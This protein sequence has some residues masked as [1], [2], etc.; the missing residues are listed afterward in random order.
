[1]APE[2]T[3]EW[4]KLLLVDEALDNPDKTDSSSSDSDDGWQ[5]SKSGKRRIQQRLR[6]TRSLPKRVADFRSKHMTGKLI[7]RFYGDTGLPLLALSTTIRIRAWQERYTSCLVDN[8]ESMGCDVSDL[9]A[10]PKFVKMSTSIP[11]LTPPTAAWC[12]NQHNGGADVTIFIR[13]DSKDL[14]PTLN[15]KVQMLFP[16]VTPQLRIKCSIQETNTYGRVVRNAPL[17]NIFLNDQ[18][19]VT[20]RQ[21]PAQR[22]AG[23]ASTT[24]NQPPPPPG[25]W[26]AAVLHGVKRLPTSHTLDHRPK[27]KATESPSMP[28]NARQSRPAPQIGALPTGTTGPVIAPEGVQQPAA[29]QGN[30][31]S[32]A[33]RGPQQPAA[34]SSPVAD[35]ATLKML[36]QLETRLT[37]M[38]QSLATTNAVNKSIANALTQLTGNISALNQQQQTTSAALSTITQQLTAL[39]HRM[40]RS[41][42]PPATM[43]QPS[44]NMG[45][46]QHYMA[47]PMTMAAMQNGMLSAGAL[48]TQTAYAPDPTAAMQMSYAHG[49]H[50]TPLSAQLMQPDTQAMQTYDPSF[51]AESSAFA[52]PARNGAVGIHG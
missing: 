23:A 44:Y 22:R 4:D 20:R 37:A 25:S 31:A 47:S 52:T 13:E 28:G 48:A 42:S 11:G 17:R 24:A 34:Q 35:S 46:Y 41:T 1:M 43:L 40:E 38:E 33:T 16:S 32:H 15:A 2:A 39:T 7:D 18:V 49:Q 8:F 36:Q 21:V 3:R 9:Q 10:D 12:V 27:K 45:P 30:G 51:V 6:R 5:Q 29:Q 19:P 14:L 50:Q 26:A